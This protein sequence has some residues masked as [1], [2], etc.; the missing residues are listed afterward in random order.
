MSESSSSSSSEDDGGGFDN[1]NDVDF[2]FIKT[3]KSKKELSASLRELI[4]STTL[5]GGVKT[6]LGT[7]CLVQDNE[8]ILYNRAEIREVS[9]VRTDVSSCSTSTSAKWCWWSPPIC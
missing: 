4:Q 2:K 9:Q 7:C 6:V 3:G 5:Q 8:D 1:P